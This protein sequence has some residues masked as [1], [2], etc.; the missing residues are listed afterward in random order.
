MATT[1]IYTNKIDHAYQSL[2]S[3]TE[4]IIK[5]VITLKLILASELNK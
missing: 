2:D 1:Y 4:V 5:I 3:K